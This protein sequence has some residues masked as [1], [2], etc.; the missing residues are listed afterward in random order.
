MYSKL[1]LLD[2]GSHYQKVYSCSQEIK[3]TKQEKIH[4]N[5][6]I[7]ISHKVLNTLSR[8]SFLNDHPYANKKEKRIVLYVLFQSLL[9]NIR[10]NPRCVIKDLDFECNFLYLCVSS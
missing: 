4:Q 7:Y 6:Y 1:R 9:S 2:P 3:H 8:C 5:K 10:V